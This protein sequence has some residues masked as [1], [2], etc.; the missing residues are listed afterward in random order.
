MKAKARS[1][2][3]LGATHDEI[4]ASLQEDV[5]S[6][7]K[8]CNQ[9]RARIALLENRLA[10][11]PNPYEFLDEEFLKAMNEIGAYGF[12]KYGS[13]SFQARRTSG[14]PL[15]RDGRTQSQAIADHAQIHFDE[16]LAHNAHDH[17]GDDVHQL[18][19]VAFNA[20]MEAIF[21]GLGKK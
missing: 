9:Q 10:S 6:A 5:A 8:M 4:K 13:Q 18:A 14:E 1:A 21:A 15:V 20:M 19:A 3:N 17:F 2:E 12:E 11:N 16:Y 7:F